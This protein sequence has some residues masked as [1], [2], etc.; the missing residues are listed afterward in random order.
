M[1]NAVKALLSSTLS[2]ALITGFLATS[3]TLLPTDAY[4]NNGKSENKGKSKDEKPSK[5]KTS[6]ATGSTQKNLA[7]E[8]S[9]LN[10][11]HARAK[12]LA[13]ASPNS[14]EGKLYAYQQ[15]MLAAGETRQ[16]LTEAKFLLSSLQG[17]TEAEFKELNPNLDYATALAVTQ[18]RIDK[19]DQA[20]KSSA[21][22]QNAAL[23]NLTGG[24]RLSKAA[25]N[26]L[27]ALLD[28]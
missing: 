9:G 25:I 7:K 14:M 13:K 4:A 19:L 28:L 20:V 10:L 6:K 2:M 8:L 5:A 24:K 15:S 17:L 18:N 27:H 3:L 23:A 26:E 21:A 22:G 12:G 16:R 1:Q 11:E